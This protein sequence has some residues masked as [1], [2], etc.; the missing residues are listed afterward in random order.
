[1]GKGDTPRPKTIAEQEFAKRWAETF[2]KEPEPAR[3]PL[4]EEED[5]WPY[6]TPS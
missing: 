3:L 1:M 6:S 5:E 4:P 2:K